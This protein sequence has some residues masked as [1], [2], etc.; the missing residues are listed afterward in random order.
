MHLVCF[1][2][3]YITMHGPLNVKLA[4]YVAVFCSRHSDAAR[5]PVSEFVRSHGAPSL[6]SLR[7]SAT[8]PVSEHLQLQLST[9][10]SYHIYLI[11]S[12]VRISKLQ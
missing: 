6:R 11:T 2:Y 4:L 9:P 10:F 7:P 12:E 1:H 5:G 8:V 3:D